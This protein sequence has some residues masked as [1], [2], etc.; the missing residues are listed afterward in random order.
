MKV[1]V[2]VISDW[3][4]FESHAVKSK[5]RSTYDEHSINQIITSRSCNCFLIT[6]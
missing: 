3:F 2:K 5:Q 6:A 1:K 4:Q